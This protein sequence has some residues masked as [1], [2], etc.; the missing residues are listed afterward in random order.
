MYS[1]KKKK[2]KWNRRKTKSKATKF[3]ITMLCSHLIL[4]IID[5]Q[6]TAIATA[7]AAATTA[8]AALPSATPSDAAI[9]RC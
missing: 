7:E 5:K 3:S 6:R 1:A 8:T 4:T 2:K 9:K